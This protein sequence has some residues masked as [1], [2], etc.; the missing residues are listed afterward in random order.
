MRVSEEKKYEALS[1]F[2]LKNKLI[3]MAK[4]HDE[5]MMLNA[6]RGN[7]NWV[8]LVPR[9]GFFQFGNFAIEESKR[10]L[11]LPR[12]GGAPEKE[13]ILLRYEQFLSEN[14]QVEGGAAWRLDDPVVIEEISDGDGVVCYAKAAALIR[15]HYNEDDPAIAGVLRL[16]EGGDG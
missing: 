6:G 10:T 3:S 5:K 12:L 13:G 8:A 7:P 11:H 15:E 2:E 16:L 1:P 4:D 14:A 9:Q